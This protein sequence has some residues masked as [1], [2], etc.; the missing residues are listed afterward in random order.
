MTKQILRIR[1]L[2]TCKDKPKLLLVSPATIWRW[3][4]I[5]QFIDLIKLG[6]STKIWTPEKIKK[7]L[8]NRTNGE[9]K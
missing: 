2:A 8:A 1:E 9:K 4:K 7:Y 5:G 3:V 6:L